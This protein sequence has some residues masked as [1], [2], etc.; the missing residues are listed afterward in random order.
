V[1]EAERYRAC[2]RILGAAKASGWRIT[3]TN[4]GCWRLTHPSGGGFTIAPRPDARAVLAATR[5]MQAIEGRHSPN[6]GS[7]PAQQ[8][9]Q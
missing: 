9:T 7:T 6:P 5:A 8:E 2:H 4:A 3:R 1:N